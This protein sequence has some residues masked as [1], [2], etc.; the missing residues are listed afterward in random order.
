MSR[1]GGGAGSTVQNQPSHG[2][3]SAGGVGWG[4]GAKTIVL[5]GVV[6]VTVDRW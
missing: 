5:V 3:R 6:G 2:I 4:G 1:G